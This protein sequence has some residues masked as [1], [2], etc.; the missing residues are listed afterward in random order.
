MS[1]SP[2]GGTPGATPNGTPRP[3]MPRKQA[4]T[5]PLM[6][7]KP[8]RRPVRPP[9]FAHDPSSRDSSKP[10]GGPKPTLQPQAPANVKPTSNTQAKDAEKSESSR[11]RDRKRF[12]SAKSPQRPEDPQQQQKQQTDLLS[13]IDAATGEKS[14]GFTTAKPG[15]Y[16]DYPVFISKKALM[17]GIRPHIARFHS[18][19][20]INLSDQKE[21]TRPVRL[22]RRD[23]M[24]PAPGGKV[25][26]LDTK[27]VE[28]EEE[29][30]KHQLMREQREA[31]RTAAMAEVAPSS[32]NPNS[33]RGGAGKRKV[34]Q[35]FAKDETEGQ[36][37]RS[38]LKYEEALPWHLE[39]FDNRQSWVGSY[40]A[41]LSNT[42]AQLVFHD[43]RFEIAPLEKWYKFTQKRNFKTEEQME[44][45]RAK[46]IQQ[47]PAWLKSYNAKQEAVKVDQDN[48]RAT[49]TLFDGFLVG[50]RVG[51]VGG[52][53]AK[54]D[55]ADAGEM[56]FEEDMADDEEDPVFEGDAEETKETEKKI[57][58]DM[59]QANIFNMKEEKSYDKAEQREKFE[60]QALKEEGKGVR[61]GLVKRER[62]HIYDSDDSGNPYSEKVSI[63]NSNICHKSC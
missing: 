60:K 59:L 18:K 17:E 45:E 29:R 56:D 20:D 10:Q 38:Q 27:D 13:L 61:K 48:K 41:A 19:L 4:P 30:Q 32:Q 14:S 34:T 3:P 37:A 58:R 53:S 49:A 35:V 40:E 11:P 9:A 47:N 5:D 50:R 55:T 21:W 62:N 63:P 43:G 15:N 8:Q 57:K 46:R 16:V 2:A 51:D 25:E 6:R 36:R 22:Q 24:A 52:A 28:I 7:R 44:A 39:D 12:D 1:A 26:Q 42:Y 54:K 23:P 33:K 31:Q